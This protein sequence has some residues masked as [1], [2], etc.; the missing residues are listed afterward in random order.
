MININ[1]I[2]QA[3]R[4][5]Q[6]KFYIEGSQLIIRDRITGQELLVGKERKEF[7]LQ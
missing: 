7:E 5:G 3:V 2:I 6:I 4:E 1:D